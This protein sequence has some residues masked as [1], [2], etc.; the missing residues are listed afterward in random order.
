M[1]A[2][3]RIEPRMPELLSELAQASV[4]DYFD[5]MLRQTGRARQRPAWASLERWLPMDVV[6]RPVL[7]RAP[8][9]RPFLVLLVIGALLAAGLA[10]YA[11]SQ[12]TPL[13]EPFGPAR[14]GIIVYS[15]ADRDIVAFD[16]AT[17]TET[18]LIAGETKDVG[19][20]FSRD[21]QQLAFSRLTGASGAL[22]VARADG[23]A[24]R[25]LAKSPVDWFDWSSSGE[26]I[27][28]TRRT[29]G[30][31][32]PTEAAIVDVVSGNARVLDLGLDIRDPVWRPGHDQIVFSA[33]VMDA[34]RAYHLVNADGSGQRMIGGVSGLA[35]NQP[36]LSPDGSKLAYAT[37]EN[38]DGT[39][40]D[41]HVLDIDTGTESIVTP[42]DGYS[43]Q[44]VLFS[45]DGTK[46]LTKRFEP[47][48]PIQLAIVPADGQGGVIPIGPSHPMGGQGQAF[49]WAFS[50]DGTEV[51]VTYGYDGSTWL[52]NVDGTGDRQMDWSAYDGQSWQRLAP[53]P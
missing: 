24:A 1:T 34:Y 10:L 47:G 48:G 50:P 15:N 9:L 31:G 29:G 3:D 33:P 46:I 11:G 17:G 40:E 16:P 26:Q 53:A 13:P 25:E 14:N 23:S 36:T 41:I 21:G 22:W 51:L 32:G 44:D 45:P 49:D 18:P 12:R 39:G 20:W 8:A 5:D 30:L 42:D 19:P 4:P 52:L 28:I 2:F 35:I 6:A 37:W 43:Y 7:V 38:G 27:A